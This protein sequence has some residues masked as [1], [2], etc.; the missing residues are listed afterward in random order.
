M[1]ADMKNVLKDANAFHN[2]FHSTTLTDNLDG[3]T[4]E[5]LRAVLLE[6]Y[7]YVPFSAARTPKHW[8]VD[9]KGEEN[10]QPLIVIGHPNARGHTNQ[11]N[12]RIDRP[13]IGLC[14]GVASESDA[15]SLYLWTDLVSYDGLLDDN[16]VPSTWELWRHTGG[17]NN[18][19]PSPSHRTSFSLIDSDENVIPFNALC[20]HYPDFKRVLQRARNEIALAPALDLN[21]NLK[22]NASLN[23]N[24]KQHNV[25]T[26][27][28]P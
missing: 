21:L 18:P 11:L 17:E 23:L 6:L 5:V 9:V 4:L 13:R 24:L 15:R 28:T 2:D 16:P 27:N 12:G 20:H 22:R 7:D 10:H 14:T 25:I 8:A 3:L 19:D 1:S 26:P